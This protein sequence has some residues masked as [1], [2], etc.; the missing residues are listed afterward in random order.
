MWFVSFQPYDWRTS[1]KGVTELYTNKLGFNPMYCISCERLDVAYINSALIIANTPEIAV[2]FKTND[3][4]M[5][6][7]IAHGQSLNNHDL[8]IPSILS[9]K[10]LKDYLKSKGETNIPIPDF[11]ASTMPFKFEFLVNRDDI[12]VVAEIDIRSRLAEYPEFE[13]DEIK[14]GL[15]LKAECELSSYDEN[16]GN[17]KYMTKERLIRNSNAQM[18]REWYA[19]I[20]DLFIEDYRKI[21]G[22]KPSDK[23][24]TTE[25]L[26]EDKVWDVIDDYNE[27]PTQE[28]LDKAV[29][30]FESKIYKG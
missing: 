23:N 26:Q 12:D 17:C 11:L 3:F 18:R 9:R 28:T 6:D 8:P 16:Y 21:I 27:N 20:N 10:G 24:I 14:E 2:F 1:S 22:L 30:Y 13:N 19:T 15:R 29:Q 25:A 5:V 7:R 4:Y